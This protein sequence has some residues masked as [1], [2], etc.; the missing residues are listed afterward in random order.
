MICVSCMSPYPSRVSFPITLLLD[1]RVF[2]SPAMKS[3]NYSKQG[4]NMIIS[5]CFQCGP[6]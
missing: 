1:H 6:S 2:K 3:L 4:Q 5:T